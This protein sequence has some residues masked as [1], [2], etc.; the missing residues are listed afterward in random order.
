MHHEPLSFLELSQKRAIYA[1]LGPKMAYCSNFTIVAVLL[2]CLISSVLVPITMR[3]CQRMYGMA[4]KAADNDN[5]WSG[6]ERNRSF[7]DSK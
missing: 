7:S 5:V 3:N 2:R 6:S 1:V 4:P